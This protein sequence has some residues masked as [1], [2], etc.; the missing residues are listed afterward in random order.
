MVLWFSGSCLASTMLH[1]PK[2]HHAE[3]I[4]TI[5]P[6]RADLR[7]AMSQVCC[8]AVKAQ[9]EPFLHQE[10]KRLQLASNPCETCATNTGQRHISGACR[11][12]SR[13]WV[14]REFLLHKEQDASKVI[15]RNKTSRQQIPHCWS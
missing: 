15:L 11:G 13:N 3:M 8:A 5:Q 10:M 9:C 14:N 1:W 7:T 4:A 2:A 12:M 6:T